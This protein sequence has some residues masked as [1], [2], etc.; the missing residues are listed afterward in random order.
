AAL[1]A[2]AVYLFRRE[3]PLDPASLDAIT[4]SEL[5]DAVSGDHALADHAA[6][7][8][9]VMA[10]IDVAVDDA[11]IETVLRFSNA[12]GLD[13]DYLR[14]LA[15]LAHGK[16]KWLLADVQRQNLLSVTGRELDVSEDAWILPYKAH[17][18]PALATRYETLGKLRTGTLG[19]TFF[20]FYRQYGFPFPGKTDGVNQEFATPH[21]STHV[22][23]GYD[24]SP[25]GELL[26]STFTAGMHPEEPM[27]GHI[28][29]VIMTWH[30]GVEL[31][32]FTGKFTGGLEPEKFWV[33]W[34][35]GSEVTTD[36]FA[37]DWD[38]WHEVERPLEDLRAEYHVP[39]LEPR[40]AASGEV[41]D[42]YQPVA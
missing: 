1:V 34:S 6:Q 37:R 17:A 36:T 23:S 30:M 7:F 39:V 33:A 35:R 21:D 32:K 2:A 31:I 16:L 24:T 9:T 28:L 41:P 29:P 11:K 40:H 22:L 5:A 27:S 3:D 19:H 13:E 12:L 42:W 20:D 10:T 8:L 26:V 14:Q 25:Q 18:D 15:A 4:P 38:F